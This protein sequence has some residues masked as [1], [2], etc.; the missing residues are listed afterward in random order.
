[1]AFAGLW[2]GFRWPDGT[3]TRSFAALTWR[4]RSGF[5]SAILGSRTNIRALALDRTARPRIDECVVEL[6]DRVCL[7]D[8]VDSSDFAS[9]TIERSS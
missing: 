4:R 3:V 6:R 5:P 9:R 8:P 2:E 1:M 7:R